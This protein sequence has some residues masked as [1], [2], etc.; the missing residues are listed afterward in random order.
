MPARHDR[1]FSLTHFILLGG[2]LALTSVLFVPLTVRAQDRVQL[3][4]QQR[5]EQL[6]FDEQDTINN[7]PLYAVGFLLDLYR[8]NRF[9]LLW[10]NPDNIRQLLGAIIASAEEGLIPDDY[11]LKTI[12]HYANER[13]EAASVAQL[14]EYDLL[15]SDAMIL[16]GQHKRYGKVNP[17]EV[18]EKHN[19]EPATPPP[20]PIDIYLAAIRT[21]TVRVTLEQR[22]PNHQAYIYLK[23]ALTRYRKIASNGG[24]P[25]VPLG[26]SLK[27]GM[28]NERVAAMRHRLAITGDYA[29]KTPNDPAFFDNDLLTAVKI[30]QNRHHLEPDGIAGKTTLGA[31][32]I[33]VSD[34]INQIRVNL[35][36]T[37]WIIR[38]MPSSC[39]IVDIAG[40]KVQYYHQN[41]RVWTSKVMVGQP[42]HQ[43]PVFRSAITYLV[44]NPTW[45]IPPNIAKNETVPSIYKDKNYLSKQRLRVLDSNGNE[46]NPDTIP[47]KQYLGRYLPYTL[48]QDAGSDSA[49]GLIKF[50]FPNPY[51]VYLHDTPSKSLFG[52]AQ[53]AFSHGC[54]RTQH[55]LVLGKLILANDPGNT[56]SEARFE[57]ILAS[58]KTSTLIL[59]QPLPIFLMYLTTSAEDGMVLFKPDLYDRDQGIFDALNRPPTPLERTTQIPEIKGQAATILHNDGK[60]I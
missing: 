58:G 12:A 36:R 30:F 22:S 20:S 59:K 38:D 8:K 44:L 46:V 24:W 41:K 26:P 45:T 2:I 49:L 19:L 7:E 9:Q 3:F 27:P 34:R 51:H 4:T 56:V 21:R 35:E 5:L 16:L 18:E 10:T 39:L 25:Q 37:R 31:M 29:R 1:T 48:R 42:F 6:Y 17:R 28:R 55:P 60:A 57:Q 32:N 11:H 47:W 50:I 23:Q 15:C 53:R 52:R 54:I 40:F 43:T 13:R 33:S 14:V